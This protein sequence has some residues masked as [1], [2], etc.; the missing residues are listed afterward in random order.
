MVDVDLKLLRPGSLQDLDMAR[1]LFKQYA[2]S[3]DFDLNFQNFDEELRRLPGEYAPPGGCLIIAMSNTEPV[4]CAALRRLDN[5][6]CEMKR[7]YTVPSLRGT[8]VGRILVEAIV[9]A[10]R[11]IGYVKMRLDT[12]PAMKAANRLYTSVGFVKI[13]PYRYNPIDGATFMEL[14]L[15][16]ETIQGCGD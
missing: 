5:G 10:A 3:L 1:Q 12:V 14:V 13:G 8:G 7:L 4:G 9:R 11:Q 6:L 15:T 2:A 16:P